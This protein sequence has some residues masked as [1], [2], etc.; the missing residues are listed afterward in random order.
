MGQH[1]RQGIELV[2]FVDDSGNSPAWLFASGVN[3]DLM[4]GCKCFGNGSLEGFTGFFVGF[5]GRFTQ[6]HGANA[7]LMHLFFYFLDSV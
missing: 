6:Q 5:F 2:G 7:P 3:D 4:A 1:R